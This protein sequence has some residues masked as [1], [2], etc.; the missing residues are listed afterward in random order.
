MDH[1]IVRRPNIEDKNT[2]IKLFEIVIQDT[3]RKNDLEYLVEMI[4]EEVEVKIKY[5]EQDLESDGKERYFLIAEIDSKI[6]GTIE[7]GA[8]SELIERCTDGKIKDMIE[9]GTIFVLPEYQGNGID[10]ICLDS[11]YKTAQKIWT[12]KFGKAQYQLKDYWLKDNDHMI[13]KVNI[14][15]VI[16]RD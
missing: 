8:S 9:L 2:L 3:F 13:W 11:G 5:L 12:K 16:L 6:I 15:E 14:S 10:E 4:E 1:V 7:Y